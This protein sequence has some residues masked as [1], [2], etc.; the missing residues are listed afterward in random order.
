MT[1][2]I[3]YTKKTHVTCQIYG[4]LCCWA[5]LCF[6]QHTF[7]DWILQTLYII[8]SLRALSFYPFFLWFPSVFS[9]PR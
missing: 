2:Q 7:L 3:N 8:N 5:F 4:V 6:Q 1:K 9:I